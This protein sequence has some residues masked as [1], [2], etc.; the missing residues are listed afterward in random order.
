MLMILFVA[1]Q[2]LQL[3]QHHNFRNKSIREAGL[4][5]FCPECI[6]Y[7]GT[8]ADG[9]RRDLSRMREPP[10]LFQKFIISYRGHLFFCCRISKSRQKLMLTFRVPG[11]LRC[12]L[13]TKVFIWF[14][15]LSRQSWWKSYSH[16]VS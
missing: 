4:N 13:K 7:K 8:V 11:F 2:P 3:K 1:I 12:Q 14:P 10:L 5:V 15:F 16:R 9:I 6:K